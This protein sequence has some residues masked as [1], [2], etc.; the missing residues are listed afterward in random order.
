[1]AFS[2]ASELTSTKEQDRL[3]RILAAYQDVI[4]DEDEDDTGDTEA[5][6]FLNSSAST[7]D[8]ASE[9]SANNDSLDDR[10]GNRNFLEAL[11]CTNIPWNPIKFA[12]FYFLTGLAPSM[13]LPYLSVYYRQLGL[14]SHEIGLVKSLQPWIAIPAIPLWGCLA[15]RLRLTRV[16]LMF[17]LIGYLISNV[18]LAFTPRIEQVDCQTAITRICNDPK[19][20]VIYT[21]DSQEERVPTYLETSTSIGLEESSADKLSYNQFTSNISKACQPNGH[22]IG[23]FYDKRDLS[24]LLAYLIVINIIGEMWQAPSPAL[25]NA[26]VLNGLGKAKRNQ[27]G[28]YKAA[29]GVGAALG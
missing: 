13:L 12:T 21:T 14:D 9:N 3:E 2:A 10:F 1:M 6:S 5:S 20:T 8:S 17:S 16:L 19:S 25:G 4:I 27:Y 18:V 11:R 22:Y 15:D 26:A 7:A 29:G 28:Y 23:Y 24:T